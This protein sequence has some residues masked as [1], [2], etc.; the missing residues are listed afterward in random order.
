[1]VDRREETCGF[2]PL[3]VSLKMYIDVERIKE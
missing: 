1:M 3:G 2:E